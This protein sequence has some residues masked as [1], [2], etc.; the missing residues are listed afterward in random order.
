[1][2]IQDIQ[3]MLPATAGESSTLW[4]ISGVALFL[5][6]AA[7]AKTSFN[8]G[9]LSAKSGAL[10]VWTVETPRISVQIRKLVNL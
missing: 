4:L 9:T 8:R 2:D 6:C 3:K 5:W 1:M 7:L 10:S